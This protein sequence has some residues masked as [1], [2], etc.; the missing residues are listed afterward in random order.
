MSDLVPSSSDD[1]NPV[2]QAA[3]V[4][5]G[6]GTRIKKNLVGLRQKY[7][8]RYKHKSIDPGHWTAPNLIAL[9]LFCALASLLFLDSNVRVITSQL[10]SDVWAFFDYMTQFGKSDWILIPTGVLGLIGLLINWQALDPR[11]RYYLGRVFADVGLIFSTVAIA[12]LAVLGLKILIG[13]ARP[14]HLEELGALDFSFFT[15]QAGYPSFPSGHSGTAAALA[16]ALACIIPKWRWTI[17]VLGFWLGVSRVVVGAHY[18]SDVI[19]GLLIG[20]GVSWVVCKIF[21]RRRWAIRVTKKGH[22]APKRWYGAYA[23]TLRI[24]LGFISRKLGALRR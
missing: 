1:R 13:R 5:V 4:V 20:G 6:I 3:G 11:P 19:G 21:A 23:E 18:P 8:S 22:I 9:S 12:G 14:K 24:S 16:I 7:R 2:R 15:F 17:L 10:P